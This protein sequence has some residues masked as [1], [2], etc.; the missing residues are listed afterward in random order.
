MGAAISPEVLRQRPLGD[1]IDGRQDQQQQ[2]R[3]AQ[4]DELDDFS[5][6]HWKFHVSR[7]RHVLSSSPSMA[8]RFVILVA[9]LLLNGFF[10]AAEV[11]LI[12]VRKKQAARHWPT[13]GRLARRPR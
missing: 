6:K 9:V 10:A 8:Y 7:S 3:Y 13:K 1:P 11:A 12:S 4:V 2:N 5:E